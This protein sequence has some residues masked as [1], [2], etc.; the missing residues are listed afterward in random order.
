MSSNILAHEA[1]AATLKQL[2]ELDTPPCVGREKE[3][4]ERVGIKPKSKN[5][6]QDLT[7]HCTAASQVPHNMAVTKVAS[8]EKDVG[9]S[10]HCEIHSNASYE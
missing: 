10:N 4:W 8:L 2:L 7:N 6:K 5:F 9:A 3:H 1:R